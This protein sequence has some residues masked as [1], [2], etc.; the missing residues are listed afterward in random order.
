[1]AAPAP[2]VPAR[3][4]PLA[5]PSP[6]QNITLVSAE[7]SSAPSEYTLDQVPLIHADD[8]QINAQRTDFGGYQPSG[9][10]GETDYHIEV[11]THTV[12]N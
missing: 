6:Q 4:R 1:M 7:D 9:P 10:P 3:K 5:A 12:A 2:P 8:S 11:Y